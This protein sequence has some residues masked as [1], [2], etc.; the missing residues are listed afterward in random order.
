MA[1]SLL[2]A[3]ILLSCLD[4]YVPTQE[5]NLLKLSACQPLSVEFW[6]T[7]RRYCKGAPFYSAS[8]SGK[9]NESQDGFAFRSICD[10][11]AFAQ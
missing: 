9:P 1:E 10:R 6:I 11:Q 2:E 7:L 5:L 3:E 4:R 8:A